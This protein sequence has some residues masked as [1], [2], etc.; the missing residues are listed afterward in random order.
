MSLHAVAVTGERFAT[1]G[2]YVPS[3]NAP[4][5]IAFQAT[6]LDGGSDVV[7]GVRSA[8]VD[9]GLAGEVPAVTSHPDRNARGDLS[10]YGTEPSGRGAVFLVDDGGV[11]T[12]ARAFYEIGPAGPTIDEAGVVAFRAERVEGVPGVHV[13]AGG[14]VRTLAERG[15]TF[16]EFFGLPLATDGAVVFRADGR[17]GVAGI[18][19][20]AIDTEAVEALVETGDELTGIAAFPCMTADGGVVFAG[21]AADGTQGTFIVRAGELERLPGGD[22]FASH[23]GALGC[24]RTVVRIATPRDGALGLFSGPDPDADRIVAIGDAFLGST[25]EALAANPVSVNDAGRLAVRLALSDG[26]EAIVRVD[27]A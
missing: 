2:E 7:V 16:E 19:R 11:R 6:L 10:F 24:G 27:L 8:L 1:F 9:A 15:D 20:A 21:T 23:R 22:A 13:V 26:R 3:V 17:D 12:F 25:V 5:E 4:G 18:Y 14:E